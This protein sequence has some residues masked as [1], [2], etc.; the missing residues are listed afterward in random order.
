MR[1][2]HLGWRRQR[3]RRAQRWSSRCPHKTNSLNTSL[4]RKWDEWSFCDFI[5]I[6][7]EAQQRKPI[8]HHFPL[9]GQAMN[10]PKE[11]HLLRLTL[12]CIPPVTLKA[13]IAALPGMNQ[14][15]GSPSPPQGWSLRERN[16]LHH[17]ATA[18][19]QWDHDGPHFPPDRFVLLGVDPVIL[20]ARVISFKHFCVLQF[21]VL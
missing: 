8:R 2:C 6:R 3:T 11:H 10:R 17:Q 13:S 21:I 16:E 4:S 9:S 20:L 5:W 19:E 12:Y 15:T 18:A 1:R 7:N 14:D